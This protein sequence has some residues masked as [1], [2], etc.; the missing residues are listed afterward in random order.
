MIEKP[1][2]TLEILRYFAKDEIPYP[3][4]LRAS[5]IYAEF[6][7]TNQRDVD[8]SIIC[9]IQNGLLVGNYQEI[10]RLDGSSLTIGF[11]SGLSQSG[12]EYVRHADKYYGKA[13][14]YLKNAQETVTTETIRLTM[15]HLVQLA[16]RSFGA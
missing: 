4:N 13:V 16:I 1:D 15:S 8:Y 14:K 12:G 5:D 11:L 2:L 10:E 9:S 3:A 7:D 6:P